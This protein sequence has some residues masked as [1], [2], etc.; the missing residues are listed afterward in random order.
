LRLYLKDD[1]LKDDNLKDDPN[2]E[3]FPRAGSLRLRIHPASDW[4]R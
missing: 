1:G 2:R 4:A 3:S